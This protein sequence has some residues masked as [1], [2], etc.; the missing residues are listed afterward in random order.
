MKPYQHVPLQF[1]RMAAA[2]QLR[3]SRDFLE[4]MAAR[5]SVRFL[6]T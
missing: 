5:R 2:E 1:E 4:R 3:A 6:F